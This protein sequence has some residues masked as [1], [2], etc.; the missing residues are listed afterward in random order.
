[1]SLLKSEN[2]VKLA[3][4]ANHN[5]GLASFKATFRG[6][7]LFYDNFPIA[8][9][10]FVILVRKPL[11]TDNNEKISQKFDVL[12]ELSAIIRGDSVEIMKFA[13][14]IL[15]LPSSYWI[16]QPRDRCI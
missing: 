13:L 8:L 9:F 16:V 7:Y 11:L 6:R 15:I 3:S 1:M 14:Y 4:S 10:V 5:S 2:I 12:T